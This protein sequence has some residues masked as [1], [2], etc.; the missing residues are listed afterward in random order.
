MNWPRIV[1]GLHG[2]LAI[3][4]LETADC[5]V[6]PIAPVPFTPWAGAFVGAGEKKNETPD[7]STCTGGP[8]GAGGAEETGAGGLTFP[9]VPVG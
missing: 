9:I 6:A 4:E 2:K 3:K 7:L 5:P 8:L 1:P